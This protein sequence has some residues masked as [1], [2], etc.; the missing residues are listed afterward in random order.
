MQALTSQVSWDDATLALSWVPTLA[1]AVSLAASAGLRAFLPLL[2]A[3]ALSR[4]GVLSLGE[5]YAFLGSTP[6]LVCFGAA[7]ALEIAGDKIP[8]V[9]HALDAGGTFVRPVA[10]SLL[11]A[12][13]M[14]QIDEPLWAMALGIV[15]G[16]P[17]ALAPHAAK[18]ATRGLSTSF[19]AGIA[20]PILSLAED[21][22]AAVIAALAILVPT[23]T[24]LLLF[25]AV[26]FAW[27]WWAR[28]AVRKQTPRAPV[29]PR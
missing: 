5:G 12:S 18:A 19:T 9:D 20:N 15:V 24:A 22:V 13:V 28:R 2:L 21:M 11:A 16:A 4:L 10:G 17:T 25:A 23:L 1:L 26:L 8:A 3:G 29:D 6:A 14:W 7:T 27:R